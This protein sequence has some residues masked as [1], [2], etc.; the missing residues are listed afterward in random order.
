MISRF[1]GGEG[2]GAISSVV[3]L[4]WAHKQMNW[5]TAFISVFAISVAINGGISVFEKVA[6]VCSCC[7]VELCVSKY[8]LQCSRGQTNRRK[9]LVPWWRGLG[10]RSF[11]W[12]YCSK[13]KINR[14][15]QT[16]SFICIKNID[17]GCEK[18][19]GTGGN[20]PRL[21]SHVIAY[22][23]IISWDLVTA[24]LTLYLTANIPMGVRELPGSP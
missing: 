8:D 19:Y 14:Q 21:P 9:G 17:L 12:T 18:L 11:D 10:L 3:P 24:V 7:K 1:Q 2:R 15:I 16:D 5:S 13:F 22:D 23:V 6:A 20:I 4:S